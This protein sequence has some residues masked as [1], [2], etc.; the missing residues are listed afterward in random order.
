MIC[1]T[2]KWKEWEQILWKLIIFNRHN[3]ISN[4]FLFFLL[5]VNSCHLI[6]VHWAKRNESGG[7]RVVDRKLLSNSKRIWKTLSM[8]RNIYDMWKNSC[9][10]H[11]DAQTY[12]L[13]INISHLKNF[14]SIWVDLMYNIKTKLLKQ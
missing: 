13:I 7:W 12:R 11:F 1:M 4:N 5:F 2:G 6:W 10:Y 8:P 14:V 9:S 3:G